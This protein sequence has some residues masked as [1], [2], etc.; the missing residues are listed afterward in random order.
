MNE[1]A[2]SVSR[3]P[4]LPRLRLPVLGGH[5]RPILC[6]ALGGLTM[7]LAVTTRRDADRLPVRTLIPAAIVHVAVPASHPQSSAAAMA[8]DAAARSAVL[9]TAAGA[10]Q[11]R[12]RFE[13]E[14]SSDDQKQVPVVYNPSSRAFSGPMWKFLLQEPVRPD[15][16]L[17]HNQTYYGVK[18]TLPLGG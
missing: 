10:R 18:V 7:L 3:L 6:C 8:R 1:I 4:D 15:I 11:V 9:R 16:D 12:N 2:V 17:T 14:S 5:W 13:S